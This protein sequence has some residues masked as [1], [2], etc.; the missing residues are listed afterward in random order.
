MFLSQN[1]NNISSFFSDFYF[2]CLTSYLS[3]R[4]RYKNHSSGKMV[5]EKI[6][7]RY[8]SK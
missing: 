2:H 5:N 1:I 6:N 8:C 3:K 4:I 7:V